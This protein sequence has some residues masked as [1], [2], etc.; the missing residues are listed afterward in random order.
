VA[1]GALD[2]HRA[3]PDLPSGLHGG[4]ALDR[5]DDQIGERVPVELHRHVVP[6]VDLLHRGATDMAQIRNKGAQ[7]FGIGPASD[8][9]DASKGFAAHSDQERILKA[10]IHRFVKFSYEIVYDLARRN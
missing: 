7:C 5:V 6:E 10:E 9:E 8:M 3:R 4:Q 1:S 2:P